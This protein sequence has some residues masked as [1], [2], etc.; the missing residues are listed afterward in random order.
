M[1][2][3]VLNAFAMRLSESCAGVVL[4]HAVVFLRSRRNFQ[5]HLHFVL[6]NLKRK[7]KPP[8]C[9]CDSSPQS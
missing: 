4:L 2:K 1:K 9:E 3:S 8:P 5:W 6:R 7:R